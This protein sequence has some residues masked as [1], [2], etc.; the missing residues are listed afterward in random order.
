MTDSELL[1]T[2]IKTGD[3]NAFEQIVRNNSRQLLRYIENKLARIN[4]HAAEDISQV[5]WLRVFQ[6][7]RQFHAGRKFAPWLYTIASRCLVDWSRRRGGKMRVLNADFDMPDAEQPVEM[8]VE[9]RDA[10]VHAALESLS[11][12]LRE[13]LMMYYFGG[14]QYSQIASEQR[15][16]LNTVRSRIRLG[17]ARMKTALKGACV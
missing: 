11:P 4:R 7:C 17:K 5:V 13:P 16:L 3:E 9:E 8:E 1:A 15:I 14:L 10:A 12:K 2:F 6:K